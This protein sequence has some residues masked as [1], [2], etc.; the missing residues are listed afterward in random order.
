M[1]RT[2]KTWLAG[3]GLAALVASSASAH[4]F[5]IL[6]SAFSAAPGEALAVDVTIGSKFPQP[7]IVVGPERIAD[8]AVVGGPQASFTAVGPGPKSM[9]TTLK[10]AAPGL[11]ILSAR[12]PAREVEYPEDRIGGI[13]EEYQVSP[14]TVRAVEAMP[15]PRVLKALS[16]RCAKSFVCVERCEGGSDPTRALGHSVEFVSADG[17]AKSFTLLSNGAPL[18]NYPAVVVTAKGER[19]HLHTTDKGGLALPSDLA[20]PVMLFAAVM[21]PPA[22]A[23]GRYTMN[24]ASLTMNA[25]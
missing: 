2:L 19:R 12:T 9:K 11:A 7:E 15:R 4:D 3:V 14:E 16:T 8:L 25:R 10:G 22:A 17:S 21:Q 18:A 6:P 1:N 5:F 13:L 23:D 20:G 24:L